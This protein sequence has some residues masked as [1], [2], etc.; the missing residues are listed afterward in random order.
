MTG[1]L[2]AALRR[3]VRWTGGAGIQFEFETCPEPRCSICRWMV[4]RINL[5]R[6]NWAFS[7]PFT[8]SCLQS[9]SPNNS[10]AAAAAAVVACAA[11]SLRTHRP[12]R[13]SVGDIQ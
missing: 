8:S 6:P 11:A 9:P 1:N 13:C 2:S 3:V 12:P 5:G 10:A 4:V 7:V